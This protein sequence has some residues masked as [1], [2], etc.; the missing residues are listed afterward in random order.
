VAVRRWL[1][2]RADDAPDMFVERIRFD[3]TRAYV[4]RVLESQAAY[5]YLYAPATLDELRER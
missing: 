2:E 1:S 5:A 4:K 3:E